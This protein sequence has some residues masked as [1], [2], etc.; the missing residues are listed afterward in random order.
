MDT[1]VRYLKYKNLDEKDS[2]LD[3]DIEFDDKMNYILKNGNEVI[4]F[5]KVESETSRLLLQLL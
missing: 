4:I 5:E 3:E 1:I 2:E